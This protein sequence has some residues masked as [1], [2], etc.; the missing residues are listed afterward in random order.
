MFL[1]NNSIYDKGKG[2][3][4]FIGQEMIINTINNYLT[5]NENEFYVILKETCKL[6]RMS[7]DF[8]DDL[9]EIK[10]EKVST[11]SNKIAIL[12]ILNEEECIRLS[13]DNLKYLID[14]Y[15]VSKTG[16]RDII[17]DIISKIL[18]NDLILAK[19]IINGIV[20]SYADNR[21]HE[22]IFLFAKK[23]LIYDNEAFEEIYSNITM[24]IINNSDLFNIIDCDEE[25]LKVLLD[26][27]WFGINS[28][29]LINFI[30]K[31]TSEI[32]NHLLKDENLN[33]IKET[34]IKDNNIDLYNLII[35]SNC[36]DVFKLEVLITLEEEK[37]KDFLSRYKV[38]V[39]NNQ[40][41]ARIVAGKLKGYTNK[42]D[43]TEEQK[44]KLTQYNFIKGARLN[45]ESK[46]IVTTNNSLKILNLSD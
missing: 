19:G 26:N 45:N 6:T 35:N 34:L 11:Q 13:I 17:I 9:N 25:R 5:F 22:V 44:E 36:S 3:V 21:E 32:Y 12:E 40:D 29:L 8:I 31:T 20:S 42:V 1:H 23:I 14:L 39:F 16:E 24:R 15:F 2:Y 37:G 7:Y 33:S 10:D 27:N 28:K 30:S 18:E 43:I 41:F 46:Y 4:K 38:A